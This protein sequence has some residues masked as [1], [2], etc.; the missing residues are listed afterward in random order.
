MP[1][2]QVIDTGSGQDTFYQ[3]MVKDAANWATLEALIPVGTTAT[4]TLTNKTLT[5]P[6]INSPTI[7][8]PTINIGSD[9]NGDIYYRAAGTLARLA[10]GTAYQALRM[11]SGATA[12]EWAAPG[13]FKVVTEARA[14][15]AASGDVAYTGAGFTPVA[16]IIFAVKDAGVSLRFISWGM[17]TG[18]SNQGVISQDG[19]GYAAAEMVYAYE[20]TGKS[21]GAA[22]KT[23]DADGMTLTWTRTGATASGTLTLYIMYMR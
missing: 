22:L 21:Q 14:M 6:T 13:S 3:G 15:D 2:F 19:T 20:D 23:L 5:S 8:T 4:Q 10:K 7:A 12:P 9:A 11:N 17:G 18:A 16:V 1:T